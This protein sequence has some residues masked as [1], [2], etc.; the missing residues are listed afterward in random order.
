MNVEE[1]YEKVVNGLVEDQSNY[2][3][4]FK[5]ARQETAPRKTFYYIKKTDNC[6]IVNRYKKEMVKRFDVNEKVIKTNYFVSFDKTYH[7]Y[8]AC[9]YPN[10][11]VLGKKPLTFAKMCKWLNSGAI[12]SRRGRKKSE[13]KYYSWKEGLTRSIYN[14][15]SSVILQ[16][17]HLTVTRLDEIRGGVTQK[18]LVERFINTK[19]TDDKVLAE[20]MKTDINTVKLFSIIWN[21]FAHPD[22]RDYCI[23]TSKDINLEHDKLGNKYFKNVHVPRESE[24]EGVKW[25]IYGNRFPEDIDNYVFNYVNPEE[26]VYKMITSKDEETIKLG[27][28]LFVNNY[29][30]ELGDI[31]LPKYFDGDQ[32]VAW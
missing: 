7:D 3:V 8:Q 6:V 14:I 29:S 5:K 19:D 22:N 2:Y 31:K 21:D 1:I 28:A 24:T 9:Y 20:L 26:S 25:Q 4:D 32:T 18:E 11:V 12:P 30:L 15:D 16:P 17:R 10:K 23:L 27:R 13:E